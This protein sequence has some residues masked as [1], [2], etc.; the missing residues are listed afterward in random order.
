MFGLVFKN[1]YLTHQIFVL[2]IAN[3]HV[4]AK[5]HN[6]NSN[7]NNE[8]SYH[9]GSHHYWLRFISFHG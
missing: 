3:V 2:T 6:N 4:I 1:C 7:D 8:L 5:A 9:I